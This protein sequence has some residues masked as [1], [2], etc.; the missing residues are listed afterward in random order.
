M[1][2]A[3]AVGLAAGVVPYP[4]ANPARRGDPNDINNPYVILAKEIEG[5][6]SD[7]C[8]SQTPKIT[9]IVWIDDVEKNPA[10]AETLDERRAKPI[11]ELTWT[12][13]NN[14]VLMHNWSSVSRSKVLRPT[15]PNDPNNTP[16]K[17]YGADDDTHIYVTEVNR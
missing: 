1:I 12:A 6:I 5:M 10:N 7:F 16:I 13:E 15:I 3:A 14:R 9:S 17:G 8:L 4:D 11:G 2:G